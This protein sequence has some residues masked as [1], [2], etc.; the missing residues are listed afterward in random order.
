MAYEM[1]ITAPDPT[2]SVITGAMSPIINA[3]GATCGVT[4]PDPT[5]SMKAGEWLNITAPGPTLT[6]TSYVSSATPELVAIA[7]TLFIALAGGF[8][9]TAPLPETQITGSD[10]WYELELTVPSPTI[11]I[12][13]TY[14]VGVLSIRA[15]P[16]DIEIVTLDSTRAT[17]S[18]TAPVPTIAITAHTEATATLA[19]SAPVPIIGISTGGIVLLDSTA[20]TTQRAVVLNTDNWEVTEYTW[21]FDQLVKFGDT[22]LGIN[23]TGI[24]TLGGDTNAGTTIDSII[25]TGLDDFGVITSKRIS[26]LC[27]G[28]KSSTDAV[29]TVIMDGDDDESYEYD[30]LATD[31]KAD[32]TRVKVG[33]PQQRKHIN[34]K[35]TNEGGADFDLY[36]MEMVLSTSI[37]KTQG[38]G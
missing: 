31:G 38:T 18:L 6:A 33:Y 36:S 20:L 30:L 26:N 34:L 10:R 29:M 7:P 21:S 3:L 11:A 8:E 17:L 13:S 9:I 37:R 16:P 14:T 32:S 25:E 12:S 22:Y 24:Y 19:L 15:P 27:V 5:I 4:A 28:W 2:V 1:L 23:S 35:L